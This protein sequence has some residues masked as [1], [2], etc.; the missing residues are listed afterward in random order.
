MVLKVS[1]GCLFGPKNVLYEGFCLCLH[2]RLPSWL[3]WWHFLL[4]RAF[5]HGQVW[6]LYSFTTLPTHSGREVFTICFHP[7]ILDELT[8][9]PEINCLKNFWGSKESWDCILF[10]AYFNK[11]QKLSIKRINWLT[12]W[13]KLNLTCCSL[14]WKNIVI[15]YHSR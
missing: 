11:L 1:E 15:W 14:F 6:M 10:S 2:C 9:N 5:H 8:W 13:I 12:N 7:L 4:F 3:S